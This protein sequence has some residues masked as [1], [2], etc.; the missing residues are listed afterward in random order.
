M[1]IWVILEMAADAMDDRIAVGSLDGGSTYSG[2]ADQSRRIAAVVRSAGVRRLGLVDLNSDLVPALLFA[3][4]AAGV[5]LVPVSYRLAED[6]LR[7]VAA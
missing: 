7:A 4:A 5:P 2:L 6:R 3:S 1:N